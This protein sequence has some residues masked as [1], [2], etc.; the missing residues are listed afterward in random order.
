VD[1]TLCHLADFNA[2]GKADYAVVDIKTGGFDL[3][4]NNGKAD[5]SVTGDGVYLIDMDN[6]GLDDYVSHIL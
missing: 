5:T 6:D 2:D 4:L 3:Y 1:W